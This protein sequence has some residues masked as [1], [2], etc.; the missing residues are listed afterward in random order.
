MKTLRI[1]IAIGMLLIN[2][3]GFSQLTPEQKKQAEAY[4][5]EK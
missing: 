3:V 4:Q 1:I 2:L 5:K